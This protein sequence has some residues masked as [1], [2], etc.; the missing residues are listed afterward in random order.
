MG[1]G[2]CDCAIFFVTICE[3][4]YMYVS[5][6]IYVLITHPLALFIFAHFIPASNEGRTK[7][8]KNSPDFMH[9]FVNTPFPLSLNQIIPFVS[10]S[11]PN[12]LNVTFDVTS[13]AS[14]KGM[15]HPCNLKHHE[16]PG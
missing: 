2:L 11:L 6:T 16:I 8:D 7:S 12:I 15:G 14:L 13:V 10:G 5:L 4:N 9:A 3:Y 1:A